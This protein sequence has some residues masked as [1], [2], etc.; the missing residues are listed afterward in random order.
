MRKGMAAIRPTRYLA[1]LVDVSIAT[2]ASGD[3]LT[4]S[5]ANSRWEAAAGMTIPVPVASGGTGATTAGGARANLGL[6][7]L[8]T[9]N[10]VSLTSQVTGILPV[11]SGGTGTDTPGLVAGSNIAISGTW[12]NQTIATAATLVFPETIKLG[13]YGTAKISSAT[14]NTCFGELAGAYY[15]SVSATVFMGQNAGAFNQGDR[16]VG[17]GV[18]A[19]YTVTGSNNVFIGYNC[20]SSVGSAAYNTFLG[21]SAGSAA[22]NST[23]NAFV[24][25]SAGASAGSSTYCSYFGAGSGDSSARNYAIAIG[26]GAIAAANNTCA[27][28]ASGANSVKVVINGTTATGQLD[29]NINAASRRG[30]VVNGTTSQTGE[31]IALLGTS[32]TTSGQDMATIT[33]A[34]SVSTH[35]SRLA[36]LVCSTSGYNGTHEAIRFSDTGSISQVVIPIAN[37]RDAADDAAAAALSPAVPVGGLYRTG[38]ILKIRVS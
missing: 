29:V 4:W 24:G 3:V 9:L 5:A 36:D 28:G 7:S 18:H 23:Y 34:W 38:S 1:E 26:A 31:L 19:G 8:A 22:S 14:G 33:T 30:L 17:I 16:T 15:P 35:A 20:G 32:S 6:G 2:P 10:S 25:S 12:P 11:A 13:T 37:V 27:I 21:Q